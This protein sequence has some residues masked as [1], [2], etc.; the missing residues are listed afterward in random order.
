MKSINKNQMKI[1]LQELP[2]D[3]SKIIKENIKSIV[4]HINLKKQ[5]EINFCMGTF[6]EEKYVSYQDPWY[7]HNQLIHIKFN[8]W[9]WSLII[10]DEFTIERGCYTVV[11]NLN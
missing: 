8:E 11:R 1:F 5:I 7:Y 6:Q 10:T 2:I 3:I 9:S 4:N